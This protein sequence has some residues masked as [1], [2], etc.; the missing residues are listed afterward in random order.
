MV[1]RDK[2]NFELIADLSQY[3]LHYQRVF[4]SSWYMHV[5]CVNSHLILTYYSIIYIEI[6]NISS[7]PFFSLNTHSSKKKMTHFFFY[8]VFSV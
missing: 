6:L 7:P 2:R 3:Q 1:L 4:N 8:V 5:L